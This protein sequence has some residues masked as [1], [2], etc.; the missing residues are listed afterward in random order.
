MG[1][2]DMQRTDRDAVAP[3]RRLE[4]LAAKPTWPRIGVLFVASLALPWL[5][6]F[7]AGAVIISLLSV[8]VSLRITK[9]WEPAVAQP[10]DHEEWTASPAPSGYLPSYPVARCILPKGHRGKHALMAYR[11][12]CPH[13]NEI[14]WTS[15]CHLCDVA[16]AFKQPILPG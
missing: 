5:V 4:L 7:A 9:T 16:E 10:C 13:G 8:V 3:R 15:T 1:Y 6:P 14:S 2:R 11:Q 12:V